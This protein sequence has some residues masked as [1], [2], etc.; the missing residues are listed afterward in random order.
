MP[1]VVLAGAGGRWRWPMDGAG[2]ETPVHCYRR[3]LVGGGDGQWWA[4]A[5][6]N[7]CCE[8]MGRYPNRDL[9]SVF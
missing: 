6:A 1:N 2:W 5:M 4:V 9:G 8:R 3:G 7:G